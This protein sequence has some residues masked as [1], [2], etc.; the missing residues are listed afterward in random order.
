MASI[1]MTP[2]LK[3]LRMGVPLTLALT[4]TPTKSVCGLWQQKSPLPADPVYYG[5][6]EYT[7]EIKR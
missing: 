4:K 3:C 1:A 7:G 5:T 6:L 2:E